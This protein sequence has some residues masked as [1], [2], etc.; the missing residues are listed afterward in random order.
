MKNIDK[1]SK[2]ILCASEFHQ[3]AKIKKFFDK[4]PQDKREEILSKF[5]EDSTGRGEKSLLHQI[6]VLCK[7][8]VRYDLSFENKNS[9]IKNAKWVTEKIQKD[10][11]DLLKLIEKVDP[12]DVEL[13]KEMVSMLDHPW[14]NVLGDQLRL[15]DNLKEKLSKLRYHLVIKNKDKQKQLDEFISRMKIPSTE[16]LNLDVFKPSN[17]S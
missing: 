8:I 17:L 4:L 6:L 15:K 14:M 5:F 10:Y 1:I 2:E 3:P 13:V 7:Q 12:K 11:D 9:E 16:E